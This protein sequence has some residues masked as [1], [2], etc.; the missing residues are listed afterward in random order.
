M[1][2]LCLCCKLILLLFLICVAKLCFTVQ[3][4]FF[5]N[6]MFIDSIFQIIQKGVQQS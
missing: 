2:S 6:G 3:K 1:K 4:A 5:L